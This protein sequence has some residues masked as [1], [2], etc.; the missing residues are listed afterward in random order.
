[1]VSPVSTTTEVIC[2]LGDS[3]GMR[4][5]LPLSL[6]LLAGC[7]GGWDVEIAQG[8][9]DGY[10]EPTKEYV[11]VGGDLNL[12]VECFDVA[13]G[14]SVAGVDSNGEL[15]LTDG[16]AT[17]RNLP[18]GRTV[19]LAQTPE[20][21]SSWGHRYGYIADGS[22]TT[23]GAGF[24][25]PVNWPDSLP[26]PTEFCGD[27]SAEAD[28]FVAAGDALVQRDAGQWWR[29]SKPEGGDFGAVGRFAKSF[30]ACLDESGGA[31]MEMQDGSVWR[32]STQSTWEAEPLRGATSLS[33]GPQG[34]IAVVEGELVYG[35][36]NGGFT[37][38]VFEE[39][40]SSAAGSLGGTWAIVGSDLL[41]YDG[42]TWWRSSASVPSLSG[43]AVLM[44][45][46]SGV[47]VVEGQQACSVGGGSTLRLSGLRP[48]QR[49]GGKRIGFEI[50]ASGAE[51]ALVSVDGELVMDEA[52]PGPWF[53]DV[54]LVGNG[55]HDVEVEAGELTRRFRFE[56][57]PAGGGSWVSDV[58]PLAREHCAL[59]GCHDPDVDDRPV[60]DS[61]QGWVDNADAVFNRVVVARD[62]PP[63]ASKLETWDAAEVTLVS[64]WIDA[65]LPENDE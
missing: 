21:L 25:Q 40:V 62:M 49:V 64:N 8:G 6:T 54:K 33:F 19:T 2:E 58:E 46:P 11:E 31:W 24:A 1:M 30:G 56:S 48:F 20:V 44:G 17:I 47:W 29:W 26:A 39:S 43:Q 59:A 22:L 35:G 7:Y 15:V 13:G 38:P 36:V 32:V 53:S 63:P 55:W 23:E 10:T 51:A 65:G 61:Y 12:T 52:G 9:D 27:P 37:I 41:H 50:E 16:T 3:K 4:R 42:E 57:R 18:S 34:V 28:G 14:E 45:A 5:I 60:L